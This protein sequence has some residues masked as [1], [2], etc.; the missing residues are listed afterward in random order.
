MDMS[1]I[2]KSLNKIVQKGHNKH[3]KTPKN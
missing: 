1:S 3:Q 2:G